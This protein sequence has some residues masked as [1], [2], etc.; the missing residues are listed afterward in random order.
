[1]NELENNDN[2]EHTAGEKSTRTIPKSL[3]VSLW[4]LAGY[5]ALVILFESL[6]GYFQPDGGSTMTITTFDG[7]GAPHERVVARLESQG[8]LYVAANHWPRAWYRQA[9]ADPRM[10][11]AFQDSV[12]DYAVVAVSGAEHD[13][14][15]DE[16][17]LG[18]VLRVLT[19]FP[20]RYFVR[21]DPR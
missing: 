7:A 1:M 21:L 9:L 10:T 2:A 8:Q 3:K 13:R 18:L 17:S 6:L 20:P 14:V 16:H 11:V 19:G 15:D 4:V 5:V 12:T